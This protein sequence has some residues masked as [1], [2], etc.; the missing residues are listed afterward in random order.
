ME[1]REG[2]EEEREG[3]DELLRAILEEKKNTQSVS[4]SHLFFLCACAHV[5]VRV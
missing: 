1:V 4:Y 3:D 2:G 5:S